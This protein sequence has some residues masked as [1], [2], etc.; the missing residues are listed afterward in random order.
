MSDV[1]Y[2]YRHLFDGYLSSVKELRLGLSDYYWIVFAV[3]VVLM[4]VIEAVNARRD[5]IES[6]SRWRAPIRWTC[7]FAV[8]LI[9]LFYGAFGVENFIYIQF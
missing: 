4:F 3:A 2:T 6:S 1:L 7:Y 9:V 5:L 8:V